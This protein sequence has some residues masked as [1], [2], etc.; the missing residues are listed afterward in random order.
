MSG[1]ER[2]V[3]GLGRGADNPFPN[4][5]PSSASR[6]S[7]PTP[8]H[9][10]V[11]YVLGTLCNPSRTPGKSGAPERSRTSDLLVRSQTLY[12]AELR[13]HRLEKMQLTFVLAAFGFAW[14]MAKPGPSFRI[15]QF[16]RSPRNYGI[17]SGFCPPLEW[18][19]PERL[20]VVRPRGR[21]RRRDRGKPDLQTPSIC[22]L[23]AS[24]HNHRAGHRPKT[25]WR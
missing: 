9:K 3:E 7:V 18:L 14:I 2:E 24:P 13:A 21:L 22:V 16:G 15:L 11:T 17:A 10:S 1:G 5:E 4:L 6:Q 19:R 12:P 25:D 20:D 23:C 8:T